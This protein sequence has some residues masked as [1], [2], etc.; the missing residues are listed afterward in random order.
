MTTT[1]NA[2]LGA[3][4]LPF[5][6]PFK[7]WT[8]GSCRPNPGPGGWGAVIVGADRARQERSG[9]EADTT[10]NRMELRAAI[11][12][13]NTLPSPSRV[14]LTTDSEYVQRG[15]TA[16]LPGWLRKGW[17]T[18][19]GKPVENR[20]LWQLLAAAAGR[21]VVEWRWVRGHTGNS[22]N[23]AADTL[24]VLALRQMLR[25]RG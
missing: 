21:H 1:T 2:A 9:A 8:D 18:G 19:K 5:A 20:D 13:L 25:E 16:W 6:G 4:S 14:V 22:M 17:V 15:M 24:A 7:I 23:E 10:N 3:V 11:E 12:A